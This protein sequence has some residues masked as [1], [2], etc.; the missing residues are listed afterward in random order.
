MNDK[1]T[2]ESATIEIEKR[3]EELEEGRSIK[4]WIIIK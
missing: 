3:N 1:T 4:W 2:T